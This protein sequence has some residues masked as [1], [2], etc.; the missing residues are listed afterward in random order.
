[1][2]KVNGI[3]EKIQ[4][5]LESF[6]YPVYY[7]RSFAKPQDDWNYLV[8]NR[9]TIQKSGTSNC[10]YNYYYQVHIIMEDYVS[11]GFEHKVINKLKDEVNL[12]LVDTPMQFNYVT[13]NGTDMVVEM[14]TITL[15][16]SIRGCDING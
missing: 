16:K 8:F 3:L 5:T 14:L 13:K 9:Y 7:G 10:D 4:Q 12:K 15:T 1:M 6:G 11:E 2:S